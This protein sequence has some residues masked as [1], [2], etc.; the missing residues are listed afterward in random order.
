MRSIQMPITSMT[1]T[2]IDTFQSLEFKL[3]LLNQISFSFDICMTSIKHLTLFL[4]SLD[5]MERLKLHHLFVTEYRKDNVRLTSVR[6]Q[7]FIMYYR[8]SVKRAQF[9]SH[10]STC[11]TIW[12]LLNPPLERLHFTLFTIVRHLNLILVFPY[13]LMPPLPPNTKRTPWVSRQK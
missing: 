1:T 2:D 10:T 3:H 7:G 12:N 4:Q 6:N 9:Q 8:L 11:W 13:F 5:V